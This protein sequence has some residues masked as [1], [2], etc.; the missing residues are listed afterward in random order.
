MSVMFKLLG[1]LVAFYAAYAAISGRVYARSGPG[2]RVVSRREE[3]RYFWVVVVIYAGLAFA[4]MT[5][6]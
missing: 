2:G 4:L 1:V 6:F 3:P 5:V